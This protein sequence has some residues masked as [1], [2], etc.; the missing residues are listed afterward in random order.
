MPAPINQKRGVCFVSTMLEI[1]SVTVAKVCPGPI[2][3]VGEI[4]SS[5]VLTSSCGYF[6]IRLRP[7]QFGIQILH[8]AEV[9][10]ARLRVEFGQHFI[11]ALLRL[12]LADAAVRVIH[13]AEDNGLRRARLRASRLH[14][15]VAHL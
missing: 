11:V 4:V 6:D 1:L 13:I 3:A 14:L 7:L 8:C 12:E 15:A 10:R 5:S 2:T 9:S